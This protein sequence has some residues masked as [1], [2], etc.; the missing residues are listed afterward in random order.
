MMVI[1]VYIVLQC[2][3]K[4]LGGTKRVIIPT[5]MVCTWEQETLVTPEYNGATGIII[6]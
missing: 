3:T 5:S 4:V 2:T 1:V 6:L